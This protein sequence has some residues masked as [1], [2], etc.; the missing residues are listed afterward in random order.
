MHTEEAT[1]ADDSRVPSAKASVEVQSQAVMIP[2][3][4]KDRLSHLEVV[5]CYHNRNWQMTTIKT[6]IKLVVGY[7]IEEHLVDLTSY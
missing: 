4:L 1:L 7:H 2:C 6:N 5:P 3:C